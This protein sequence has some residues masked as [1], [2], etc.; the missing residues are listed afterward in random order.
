MTDENYTDIYYDPESDKEGIEIHGKDA[1]LL[2]A[3]EVLLSPDTPLLTK[4]QDVAG[5][6]NEL[7]QSG[8]GGGDDDDWKPP[9]WWIDIPE[10]GEFQ[11]TLLV[12]TYFSDDPIRFSLYNE[13]DIYVGEGEISVDWGD[14]TVDI[15]DRKTSGNPYDHKYA[16]DGQYIVTIT[17]NE[18]SNYLGL[19]IYY[20]GHKNVLAVKYGVSTGISRT[21][22]SYCNNL[23]YIKFKGKPLH[24]KNTPFTLSGLNS[25]AKLEFETEYPV[26]GTFTANSFNGCYSLKK[27]DFTKNIKTFPPYLFQNCYSLTEIDTS[28][29]IVLNPYCFYNC[30]NLKKIN[31][32]LLENIGI[33]MFYNCYSL[34][35]INTPS[36]MSMGNN[37]CVNCYDLQKI[38]YAEGCN[39]NGNTFE[40][41][42]K[43]YPKPE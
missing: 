22:S 39:F 17:T 36:L 9:E 33:Y 2:N 6:I 38:N 28:S 35:E 16:E 23:L 8:G 1:V 7:F 41:T 14:G 5:A 27:A 12:C 43:L 37:S 34:Q 31:A 15:F 4:A 26:D 25:L 24:T 40:N 19:D 18:S 10:P 20:E 32:P 3:P 42:P 30:Y 13:S 11:I 29:A 21:F